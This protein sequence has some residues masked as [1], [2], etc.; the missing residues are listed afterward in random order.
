MKIMNALVRSRL[1]FSCQD[2]TLANRQAHHVNVVFVF[3]LHKMVK[4]GCKGK[5]GTFLY[6]LSNENIYQRCNRENFHQFIAQQQCKF[7]AHVIRGENNKI[8]NCLLFNN[9]DSRKKTGRF[10]THYKT[11][12]ENENYTS[13]FQKN[14][15]SPL[16]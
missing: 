1:T 3:M 8:A 5:P 12:S 15:L 13:Y 2:W 4:G 10:V 9:D 11:V 7:I 14:A 6:E 16:F